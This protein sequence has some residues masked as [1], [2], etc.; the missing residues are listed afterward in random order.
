M[1]NENYGQLHS[2]TVAY[3]DA[4]TQSDLACWWLPANNC[5]NSPTKDK[6]S[7]K[8]DLWQLTS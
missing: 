4:F 8:P 7:N 5:C 3:D 6:A 2:R 1:Y